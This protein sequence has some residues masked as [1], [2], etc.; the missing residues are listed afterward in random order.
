LHDC[1]RHASA[2]SRQAEVCIYL[3]SLGQS[4]E[5]DHNLAVQRHASSD[6]SGVAALRDNCDARRTAGCN[7]SSYLVGAPGADDCGR[8]ANETAGPVA[9]MANNHVWIGKNVPRSDH[10]GERAKKWTRSHSQ[11]PLPL[12]FSQGT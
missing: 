11:A 6:Q 9:R 7:Y 10:I 3:W 4:P 2:H 5:A 1:H 12:L 8:V